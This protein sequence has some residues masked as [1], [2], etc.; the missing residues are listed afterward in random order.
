MHPSAPRLEGWRGGGRVGDWVCGVGLGGGG[1]HN[2]EKAS[3]L[4]KNVC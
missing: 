1:A 3:K 4:Q 2:Y